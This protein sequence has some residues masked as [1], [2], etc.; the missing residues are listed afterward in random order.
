MGEYG[1]CNIRCFSG[2]T[3][4]QEFLD[5]HGLV[6]V[7]LTHRR[8]QERFDPF[9]CAHRN[10]IVHRRHRHRR[11][12]L[13]RRVPPPA[14]ALVERSCCLHATQI[15]PVPPL[16]P[17]RALSKNASRGF[18]V[19]HRSHFL[20]VPSTSAVACSA[21][22]RTAPVALVGASAASNLSKRSDSVEIG[23]RPKLNRFSRRNLYP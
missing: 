9:I 15:R 19:P 16:P 2:T 17:P 23:S 13:R 20:A 8:R 10:S 1:L 6:D 5:H 3:F 21:M 22:D 14:D 11:R 7:R 12:H 18:I 4:V